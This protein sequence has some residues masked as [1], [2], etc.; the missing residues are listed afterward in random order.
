[1]SGVL[2]FASSTRFTLVGMALLAV[3]AALSYENPAGTPVWVLVVPMMLLAVNLLLAI[4]NN[5]AIN[6]RGGLLLFHIGLL[7]VIT[8]AAVGRLTHM[9][10]HIELV[11]GNGFS[12]AELFDVTQGPL[13]TGD[14]EKIQFVQ[15]SWTVDYRAG[16]KRGLTL[17][18]ISVAD[19]NGVWQEQVIG[20]D[21]PL[22][23]HGFRIYTTSNKG[24]APVLTWQP[25][26]G[27]AITG[28]INMPSYPIN[29]F[30]Q[31]NTWTPP[32]SE[33]IK[34][35]L[36]LDTGLNEN[37]AWL[38]EPAR[39][40]AQLVV[41]DGD[42]RV[43]LNLGDTLA[44][45]GGVLRFDSLASW[46]GYKVFYDPTLYWLFVSSVLSV[47]GMAFHYWKKFSVNPLLM[48]SIDTGK[49]ASE[50]NSRVNSTSE[51]S[52]EKWV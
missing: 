24:F 7:G 1:M 44:L 33:A 34:F 22:L 32:G 31:T 48:D 43:E 29:S 23:I 27:E 10:A 14:V 9:Q 36:N 18:T 37:A 21:R 8:L 49:N 51:Y 3:G 50:N 20:D 38:L 52:S 5:P 6:R 17:D 42:Q 35:W 40:K 16:M 39:A 25:E 4:I 28:A 2:T 45:S 41:N 13:H 30:R 46:M 26:R 11:S 15:G 19:E 12:S 47:L